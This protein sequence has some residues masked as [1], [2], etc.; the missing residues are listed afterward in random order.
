MDINNICTHN[1]TPPTQLKQLIYLPYFTTKLEEKVV[2]KINLTTTFFI[3]TNVSMITYVKKGKLRLE[4]KV[5]TSFLFPNIV[6][7]RAPEVWVYVPN[8]N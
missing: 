3:A 5:L 1:L 4:Q 6:L 8:Y 2:S 7:E